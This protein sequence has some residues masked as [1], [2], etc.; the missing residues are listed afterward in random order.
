M[1]II[2]GVKLRMKCK[3]CGCKFDTLVG[4]GPLAPTLWGIIN[5]LKKYPPHC[6]KCDG[7]DTK[8]SII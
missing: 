2:D 6:P 3:N 4:F 1:S 8:I 5:R 7:I